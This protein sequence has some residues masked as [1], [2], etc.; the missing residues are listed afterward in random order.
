MWISQRWSSGEIQTIV[1]PKWKERFRYMSTKEKK[2]Q[3]N[4]S[5]WGLLI[6]AEERE[7][8]NKS[9]WR[10]VLWYT[11]ICADNF[12]WE[13]K[14]WFSRKLI[15]TPKMVSGYGLVAL[16]VNLLLNI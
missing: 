16:A 7:K 14:K 9:S 15:T 12:M 6:W 3:E 8:G 1:L 11:T 10:S 2:G 4:N 13:T 5:K